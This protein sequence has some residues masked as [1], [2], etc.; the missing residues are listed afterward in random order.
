MECPFQLVDTKVY[1]PFLTIDIH[2]ERFR[3]VKFP[4]EGNAA[5][6][7][8]FSPEEGWLRGWR[9]RYDQCIQHYVLVY[10]VY[11]VWTVVRVSNFPDVY[12]KLISTIVEEIC[13]PGA[14]SGFVDTE[15]RVRYQ[16]IR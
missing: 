16:T 2:I 13:Y 10:E 8:F 1:S 4:F 12:H 15:F 6:V 11:R 3:H 14:W 9:H 7:S 5:T